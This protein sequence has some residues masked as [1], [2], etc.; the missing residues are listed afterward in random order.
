M[1]SRG[2]RSRSMSAEY[3]CKAGRMGEG[4]RDCLPLGKCLSLNSLLL[5]RKTHINIKKHLRTEANGTDIQFFNWFLEK[6]HKEAINCGFACRRKFYRLKWYKRGSL[7]D[8]VSG[9]YE[10][11]PSNEKARFHKSWPLI[12][13]KGK[14]IGNKEKSLS[15]T[16]VSACFTLSLLSSSG[17]CCSVVQ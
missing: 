14:G 12:G 9:I 2:W 7:P 15:G 5:L 3:P 1:C 6:A 16:G 10:V 8:S 13:Q 4:D 11:P 17:F